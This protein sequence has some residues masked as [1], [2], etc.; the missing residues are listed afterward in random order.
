MQLIVLSFFNNLESDGCDIYFTTDGSEPDT[1]TNQNGA[2][3]I[4][5]K[6]F[7]LKA[8]K[9]VIRAVTQERFVYFYCI[10]HSIMQCKF[11]IE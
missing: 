4:Y 1:L 10:T 3:H 2:V 8:G 7:K 9:R 11:D 6:P 5:R